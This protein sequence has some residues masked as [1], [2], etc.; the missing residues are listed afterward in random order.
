MDVRTEVTYPFGRRAIWYAVAGVI[1]SLGAPIGLLIL[2]EL[3]MPTPV[4]AELTSNAITYVYV[5]LSTALVMG[6]AG[7]VLGRQADRL[8]L[9]SETDVLTGLPNRR[10]LTRRLTAEF[11]RAERY[12]AP[13][14]LLFIDIDDFKQVN[15]EQ[16]HA[17][18][19]RLIRHVAAG[20]AESLRESDFGARWGGDEFAV[21]A[22]NTDAEAARSSAER[23]R[24]RVARRTRS[25]RHRPV[26]V[27]VGT[28]TFDP[29]RREIRDIEALVKAA[30]S[31]LYRAKADG[32][33]RV[34]AA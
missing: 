7:F 24:A 6:T 16:G 31:A 1:L 11:H 30:D 32:R 15:D 18:G 8:T 33:N 27:S 19:D 20:I 14:S 5:F 34:H 21:L 17:A 25:D 2:H 9:L 10:A 26:T 3:Y 13:V 12:G 22:P 29:E 28:S 23:L 4:L